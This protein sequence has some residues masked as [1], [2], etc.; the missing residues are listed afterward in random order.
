MLLFQSLSWKSGKSEK[1]KAGFDVCQ[2]L[3]GEN[4][5]DSMPRALERAKAKF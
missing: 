2:A 5:L 1:A 4:K 3:S